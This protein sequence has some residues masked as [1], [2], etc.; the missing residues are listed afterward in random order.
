[1]GISDVEYAPRWENDTGRMIRNNYSAVIEVDTC[2]FEHSGFN[3][4]VLRFDYTNVCSE[5]WVTTRPNSIWYKI[6][7]PQSGQTWEVRLGGVPTMVTLMLPENQGECLSVVGDFAFPV[8]QFQAWDSRP[9][10]LLNVSPLELRALGEFNITIT[11]S[12]PCGTAAAGLAF[13]F[14]DDDGDADKNGTAAA[15]MLQQHRPMNKNGSTPTPTTFPLFIIPATT[16]PTPTPTPTPNVTVIVAPV[17]TNNQSQPTNLTPTLRQPIPSFPIPPIPAYIPTSMSQS[18]TTTTITTSSN[19]TS[20]DDNNVISGDLIIAILAGL[21]FMLVATLAVAGA[22]LWSKRRGQRKRT[23]HFSE[24]EPPVQR[25]ELPPNQSGSN[26]PPQSFIGDEYDDDNDGEDT[27]TDDEYDEA[28]S[29]STRVLF[30]NASSRSTTRRNRNRRRGTD[31][32]PTVEEG[33]MEESSHF[34]TSSTDLGVPT[35][36][37]TAY[38]AATQPN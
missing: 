28:P 2:P 12:D 37:A 18:P 23:R 36:T 19:S 17:P 21:T 3:G 26:R 1:M 25:S 15:G 11:S 10:F 7:S 5:G 20:N 8:F 24:D 29:T 35:G 13:A 33:S 30:R 32:L 27:E 4:G 31:I 9:F 22:L 6:Y 14:A 16:V 38:T 34:A